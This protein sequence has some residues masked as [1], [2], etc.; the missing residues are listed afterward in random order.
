MTTEDFTPIWD[1]GTIPLRTVA[2]FSPNSQVCPSPLLG[3][4]DV[5]QIR[6]EIPNFQRGLVWS[7]KKKKEFLQSLLQGWPT[8]AI[9][10]TKIESKDLT[11][12]RR[13]F[14]WH[15]IDGQQR[16]STFSQ[17]RESFW[18]EPW[19]VETEEMKVAIQD[20]AE[21]L[22]VAKVEDI[23]TAMNLLTQGDSARPFN[24]EYLDESMTF[25]SK[26]C[27]LLDVESPTQ[28]EEPRYA[29]ALT[30]C[31]IIRTSLKEQKTS[32]DNVPIAVITISP[33]LGIRPR[34]AREISSRIFERLNSGIP[35]SKYDLL[36]AKW[37]GALVPWQ[38][39]LNS[40]TPRS[41]DDVVT[42]AQ[43]KYMLSCMRNRIESSYQNF[44]EDTEM[45]EASIEELGEEEVSLFDYLYALSKSTHAYATRLQNGGQFTIAERL[46]FP[47]GSSSGTIAFDTCS[48]LFSGSLGPSGIEG[49]LRLFPVHNAEYD[50]SSVTEHYLDAAKEIEAKLS[51]F[52]KHAT[53]N[54]KRAT[55]GTI[56]ASVYLAAYMNSVHDVVPGESNRLRLSKRVGTRTKSADGN[57]N[58][59]S[60][61]RKNN[62]RENISSWWLLHTIS[63]IFQG[64]DAYKQASQHVW[65]EMDIVEN[66]N[67][68]NVRVAKENDFL[69]YQPELVDYSSAFKS[70]FI[71]EFR[72]TQAP[73][74]RVPSQS[75][76]AIFH[77][78]YK[79]KNLDMAN[80]DMDHVVA[81]RAQRNA[82]QTRL[83]KPIPLNHVANWLPLKPNLNRSR[84][85]TPWSQF[86]L[87][88]TASDQSEITNDLLIKPENLNTELL[89]SVD[90][91][92]F[93][94]LIR[95]ANMIHAA[96]TNVGLDE[97]LEMSLSEKHLYMLELSKDLAS[98][99]S[100]GFDEDRFKSNLVLS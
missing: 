87:T 86:Y 34:E 88:L 46:S 74:T 76:L 24:E 60:S 19:Y 15:V 69:L 52:T 59:S 89:N 18:S 49:L 68:L 58:F 16:L 51:I 70:L 39:F 93:V 81:Y 63:D 53:K 31:K 43:K 75:A 23:S 100:I 91:F 47:S 22:A 98:S 41:L 57:S 90:K 7:K 40:T 45:D 28:A 14:T 38:N 85:N 79:Y 54:K 65:S 95:F 8:G 20:L 94:M 29:K 37:V 73:M 64:S 10:V 1:L 67:D 27:R 17:F 2:A 84:Q 50:I 99:L 71:K 83:D 42:V 11:D 56:Q 35:L 21:T 44:L 97:Y 62:F 61:Q 33:K 9:V 66:G 92:G 48:L 96:L 55:L 78:A 13:E 32:L 30:A 26:I 80:F 6:F 72:V 4:V 5:D 25:L 3:Q 36:A 82:T 12:G 77:A